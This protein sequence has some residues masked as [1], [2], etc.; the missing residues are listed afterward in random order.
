ML[1]ADSI[2]LFRA[3][4]ALLSGIYLRVEKGKPVALLGTSGSG[5]TSLLLIIYGLLRCEGLIRIDGIP[6]PALFRKPERLRF[7]PQASMT[8][9][10]LRVKTVLAHFGIPEKA[11][12]ADF[13]EFLPLLTNRFAQLSG[14]EQ[15]IVELYCL[16]HQ[17][18]PY[19]LLDEPFRGM[20]PVM[21]ER[22]GAIVTAESRS[23]GILFTDHQPERAQQLA[24]TIWMLRDGHLT[25][26]K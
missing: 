18:S 7:L 8:P 5:K 3:G 16:L 11:F 20:S 24:D 25:R 12:T 26:E 15:R 21:V 19:L 9:K 1:E 4:R 10:S 23:K 17:Q 6:Q 14:G 22:F 13:P 2:R